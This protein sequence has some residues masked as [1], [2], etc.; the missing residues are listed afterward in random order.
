MKPENIFLNS[1]RHPRVADFGLAK[2]HKEGIGMSIMRGGSRP[3]MAPEIL[4]QDDQW[5]FAADVYAY[6]IMFWEIVA[7]RRWEPTTTQ[8]GRVERETENDKNRPPLDPTWKEEHQL[9]LARMWS[10]Q[11]TLRPKFGGIAELLERREYWLPDTGQDEFRQY[12]DRLKRK[13]GEI[14]RDLDTGC[15]QMLSRVKIAGSL[16]QILDDPNIRGK[17]L[18]DCSA[19]ILHSLGYLCGHGATKNEDVMAA[20]RP[21]LAGGQYLDRERINQQAAEPVNELDED[22]DEDF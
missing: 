5:S 14:E 18:D 1:K 15:R 11:V 21:Y 10:K 7:G 4:A 17:G 8:I 9:L 13:E 19:K 20:V 2:L 3:Y 22:I 12:I 16:T 6:A